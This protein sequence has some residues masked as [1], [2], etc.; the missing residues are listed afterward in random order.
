MNGVTEQA[1][2]VA[3]SITEALKSTPVVLA[4]VGF[5]V[6]FMFLMTY[7]ALKSSERWEHEIERWAELVKSCQSSKTP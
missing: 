5:N 3:S 4:L 2:K 7:A 1:A 6:L